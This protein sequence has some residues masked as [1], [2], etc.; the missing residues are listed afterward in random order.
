MGQASDPRYAKAKAGEQIVQRDCLIC[1]KETT[2]VLL[3]GSFICTECFPE[4]AGKAHVSGTAGTQPR[5]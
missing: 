1:R 2:H 3:A 4:V 5:S